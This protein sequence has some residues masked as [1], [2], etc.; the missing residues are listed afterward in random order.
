MI[1][2]FKVE[3]TPSGDLDDEVYPEEEYPFDEEDDTEEDY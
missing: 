1:D 3:E 2:C